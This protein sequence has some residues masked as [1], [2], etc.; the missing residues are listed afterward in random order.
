[1]LNQRGLATMEMIPILIIFFILV[2]FTLGF[3]GVIH[4]GILNSMAARNYAFETFRNRANLNYLRD[5]GSEAVFYSNAGYRYHSI[6]SES[7]KGQNSWVATQRPIQFTENGAQGVEPQGDKNDHNVTVRSMVEA[8]P[9]STYFPGTSAA[10]GDAG[11]DP[12][13]IMTSYGICLTATCKPI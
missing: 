12:V 13:W 2:N 10:A 5:E 11:L 6:I 1:M 3:F 9:T 7:N 8:N 4:S